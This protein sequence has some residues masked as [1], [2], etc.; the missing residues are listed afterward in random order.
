MA[1]IQEKL[2]DS[3]HELLNVQQENNHTIVKSSELSRVHLVRLV[4]S[5]FFQARQY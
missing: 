3:L 4:E 1:T 2:A 5:G